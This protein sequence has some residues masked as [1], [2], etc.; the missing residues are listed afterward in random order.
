MAKLEKLGSRKVFERRKLQSTV[1]VFKFEWMDLRRD[2]VLKIEKNIDHDLVLTLHNIE[3]ILRKFLK[4]LG[5]EGQRARRCQCL[6][7]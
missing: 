7:L 1:G 5:E 2:A 3:Q 4:D 6:I